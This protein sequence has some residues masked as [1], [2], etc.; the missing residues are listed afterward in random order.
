MTG[1]AKTVSSGDIMAAHN[2]D[3]A[4][5]AL[6][7]RREGK[8]YQEIADELGMANRGNAHRLVR[9]ALKMTL[10]EPADE[11]RALDDARI[12]A[13]IQAHWRA[14]TGVTYDEDMKAVAPD[15]AAGSLI[16]KAVDMHVKLH[17]LAMPTK[18]EITGAGGSPLL[19]EISP[20]LLPDRDAEDS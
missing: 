20:D 13:I 8:S 6:N 9:K 19:I 2:V 4:Q 17:G 7:L 11:L 1:W 18:T 10:Q 15:P 16:L 5:T 3:R 14:A 12:T